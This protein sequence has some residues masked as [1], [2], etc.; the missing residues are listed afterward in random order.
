MRLDV[1]QT[2]R[3]DFQLNVGTVWKKRQCRSVQSIMGAMET[4]LGRVWAGMGFTY[5]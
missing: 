3:V 5:V 4:R 1:D 2:A